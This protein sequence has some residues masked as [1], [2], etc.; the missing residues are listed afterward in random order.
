MGVILRD[1][2]EQG[3]QRVIER[4]LDGKKR[5]VLYLPTA[6]GKTELMI[7]FME[8]VTRKGK[9]ALFICDRRVLVDQTSERMFQYGIEHGKIMAGSTF[10]RMAKIKV[11]SSQTLE[12][13]ESIPKVDLIVVDECHRQR[14]F[15][16]DYIKT[17]PKGVTVI[18]LSAS[19][20]AKGLGDVYD[21]GVVNI[22]THFELLK[23]EVLSELR[24]YTATLLDLPSIE[25]DSK[26]EWKSES[27]ALAAQEI[28]GNVVEEWEKNTFKEFDRPV[29]T[30]VFSSTVQSGIEICAKFKEAGYDFRVSSYKDTQEQTDRLVNGFRNGE[31]IGLCCVDKF[32]AGFDVPDV[33]MGILLRPFT[34]SFMSVV[35][36]LGRYARVAEGK[37]FA[38]IND[39]TDNY[40]GF[41]DQLMELYENGVE[42]LPKGKKKMEKP[43]KEY[44]EKEKPRCSNPECGIVLLPHQEECPAC[45]TARPKKPSGIVYLPGRME[46]QDAIKPGS[47][48]W[49]KNEQWVWR[50]MC[51]A[52]HES[53]RDYGT[54]QD[55]AMKY[56]LA[57][58]KDMFTTDPDNPKWPPYKWGREPVVGIPDARVVRAMRKQ[59][60]I[61]KKSIRK[62]KSW[63]DEK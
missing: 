27:C 60:E 62:R 8:G 10:G 42:E 15:I 3:K 56:A 37:P 2:Q 50:Q 40:L 38:V 51:K 47:R 14:K 24:V 33:M 18:G 55:K 59:S 41:L 36:I 43:R 22:S 9:T 6:G 30:L 54:T 53:I 32:V 44:E 17:K 4:L 29:K 46:L 39:H 49:R 23:K 48:D 12:K 28:I 13:W 21:G 1:Y 16:S 58:F 57:Q 5:I 7:D 45:G 19:P 20:F 52:A 31:F 61:F 63:K 34:K 25:K 35:Q 26:G 11:A